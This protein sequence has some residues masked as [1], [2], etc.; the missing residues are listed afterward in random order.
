MFHYYDSYD[1]TIQQQNEGERFEVN[2]DNEVKYVLPWSLWMRLKN[3]VSNDA[4]NNILLRYVSESNPFRCFSFIRTWRKQFQSRKQSPF[5]L[6]SS[7]K[8]SFLSCPMKFRVTVDSCNQWQKPSE[9]ILT[10]KFNENTVSHSKEERKSRRISGLRRQQF[11]Q[12]LQ[13][14]SPSTLRNRLYTEITN[15]ELQS[16]K[17]DRIGSSLSIIQK[18]SSEANLDKQL[19][20]DLLTSLKCLH[21]VMKDSHPGKLAGY[22]QRIEAEPFGVM[23]FTKEGVRLYHHLAKRQCIFFDATGTVVS[24]TKTDYEGR[25][26]LYYSLVLQHPAAKQP[27]VAVAEYI[28]SDHSALSILHFLECFKKAEDTLYGNTI[29][30]V[31]VIIDRSQTLLKSC[32]QVYFQE[33]VPLYLH[34]CFR[35]VHGCSEPND[36]DK[37]FIFACIAH[38]MKSMK[39]HLKA[40]RY[41]HYIIFK[42]TYFIV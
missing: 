2:I 16:G 11:R 33:T 4:A 22:I 9:L 27:P 6:T 34:R 31:K 36:F 21:R 19:H 37:G 5:L 32:T 23:C 12:N 18:I 10:V 3:P 14:Q 41:R 15:E 42:I 25:T 29:K 40:E 35:V 30:P 26:V 17:R 7:G 39:H 8:C 24:L 38:V 13:Q 1:I 20:S 28:T